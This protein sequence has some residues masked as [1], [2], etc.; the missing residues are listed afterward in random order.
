M[1]NRNKRFIRKT[2]TGEDIE[3]RLDKILFKSYELMAMSSKWRLTKSG[4]IDVYPHP[5]ISEDGLTL[6]RVQY[7]PHKGYY[8]PDS[9]LMRHIYHE[10]QKELSTKK[11]KIGR[12]RKDSENCKASVRT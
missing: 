1:R 6:L 4:F 10:E 8:L 9:L 5:V 12:P 3:S 11:A 2:D 7:L